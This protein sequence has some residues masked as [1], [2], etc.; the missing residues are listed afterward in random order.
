MELY[1]SFLKLAPLLLLKLLAKGG[2]GPSEQG[3][4]PQ[5][6]V[7]LAADVVMTVAV[8][9]CGFIATLVLGDVL[10]A[11]A[12]TRGMLVVTGCLSLLV[13]AKYQLRQ[14]ASLYRVRP[15]ARRPVGSSGGESGR[16]GEPS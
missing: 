13:L 11:T 12:T 15:R 6:R 8:V 10:P 16:P 2:F 3:E 14:V 5:G 1:S 4:D 7:A 9:G